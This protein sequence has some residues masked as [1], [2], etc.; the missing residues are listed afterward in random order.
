[1]VRPDE[2][3]NGFARKFFECFHLSPCKVTVVSAKEKGTRLVTGALIL[4][5]SFL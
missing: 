1:M 4:S 2:N 5:I 3:G